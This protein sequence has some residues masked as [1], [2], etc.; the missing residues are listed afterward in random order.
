VLAFTSPKKRSSRGSWLRSRRTRAHFIGAKVARV[1]LTKDYAHDVKAMA[2]VADA[3][4]IYVCNPNNPTGTLT[5]KADIEWLVANKPSGAV[6]IG[7]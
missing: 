3:G 1:P 2:A 5:P 7:R 4:L 6:V